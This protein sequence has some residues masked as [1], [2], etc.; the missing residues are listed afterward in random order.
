MPHS[1]FLHS[2]YPKP[3]RKALEEITVKVPSIARADAA[4][5][6]NDWN[7]IV[8]S[9]LPLEDARAFQAGLRTLGVETDLIADR[10][11]PSL[12]H[13]FRCQRIDLTDDEIILSTSMGR[14][15]PRQR[16][17]LVFIAAGLLDR[18][19]LGRA[20]EMRTEVR[21]TDFGAYTTQVRKNVM[22]MEEKRFFRVDLFFGTDPHR[23][24]L[25]IDKESICFYGQNQIRIK[26]THNLAGLMFDL[27]SLLPPERLNHSL[28]DL[29]IASPYPSMH[30]Y[31]EEIR[32][33]FYRLGAK[34]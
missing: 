29:S 18:E 30:A 7:G 33:A 3:D 5:I 1:L 11:I 20:T 19:K 22:K 6:L 27:Q 15:Y 9:N 17:D 8:C 10:D 28:R 12:H 34:G 32:W 14:R 25:E 21:Y 16:T 31:E 2:L 24:S 26:N 13:D 4:G 23:I